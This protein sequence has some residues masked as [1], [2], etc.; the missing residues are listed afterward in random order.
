M[1]RLPS[2]FISH[3]S[4]ML[5]LDAGPTGA[6]WARIAQSLPRPR[7]I[8]VASAHWLTSLPAVSTT[9]SP[10]N[11]HD[12]HGFPEPLFQLHYTP[13]GAPAP[14]RARRR[15]AGSRRTASGYRPWPW[16]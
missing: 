1:S 8:L 15:L 9:A 7:A 2:L 4:P 16:P 11:I 3:G 6:A 5:A 12:F 10:A 13:P 14:G